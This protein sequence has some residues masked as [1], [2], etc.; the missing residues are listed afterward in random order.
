[1]HKYILLDI[2]VCSIAV[3]EIV[4]TRAAPAFEHLF[5]GTVLKISVGHRT[6]SYQIFEN[7]RRI[8]Q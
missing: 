3:L 1:M 7:V 6:L 4:S 5:M 8:L 2:L